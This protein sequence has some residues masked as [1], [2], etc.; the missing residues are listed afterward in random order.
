[1][2]DST[3]IDPLVI[4]IVGRAVDD[5]LLMGDTYHMPEHR[6]YA[7]TLAQAF[8]EQRPAVGV[9]REESTQTVSVATEIMLTA[10]VEAVLLAFYLVGSTTTIVDSRSDYVRIEVTGTEHQFAG[11]YQLVELFRKQLYALRDRIDISVNFPD[12]AIDP[13]VRG[14]VD[15]FGVWWMTYTRKDLG[16]NPDPAL[17]FTPTKTVKEPT[18]DRDE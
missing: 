5:C 7:V 2:S 8:A 11:G 9:P 1:M 10:H 12:R 13:T 18:N 15:E 16:I 14:F 3:D 6:R 4:S 17:Q